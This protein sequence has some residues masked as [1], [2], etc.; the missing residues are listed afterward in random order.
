MNDYFLA[1]ILWRDAPK[2]MGCFQDLSGTSYIFK[3]A[4]LA[5]GY[6]PSP[7]HIV[8]FSIQFVNESSSRNPYRVNS[9]ALADLQSINDDD[10]ETLTQAYA[11]HCERESNK[12]LLQQQRRERQDVIPSD[13]GQQRCRELV[14][15]KYGITPLKSRW[16]D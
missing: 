4:S 6:E 3:N 5:E 1:V 11:T 16:S 12:R 13:Y 10:L 7:S 9:V 15:E 2:G 8:V 14:Q